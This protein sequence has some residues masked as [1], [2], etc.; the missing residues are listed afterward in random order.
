[1]KHSNNSFILSNAGERHFFM[2]KSWLFSGTKKHR[3]MDY[4]CFLGKNGEP[5][6]DNMKT[7]SIF[8]FQRH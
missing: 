6:C 5:N 3:H 8:E 2:P 4:V 7:A 1:M